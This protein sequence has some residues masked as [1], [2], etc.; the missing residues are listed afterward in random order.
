[1][2]SKLSTVL[3][4]K[5]FWS[6]FSDIDSVLF[7][8]LYSSELM[9]YRTDSVLTENSEPDSFL[10]TASCVNFTMTLTSFGG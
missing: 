2:C 7:C 10:V 9:R 5:L 6:G 8:D 3:H 1:M 4:C